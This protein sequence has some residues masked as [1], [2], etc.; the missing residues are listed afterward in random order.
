[1]L[2]GTS[3]TATAAPV[4]VVL[5]VVVVQMATAKLEKKEEEEE[6]NWVWEQAGRCD[7]AGGYLLGCIYKPWVCSVIVW[8]VSQGPDRGE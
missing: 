6:E 1:M 2:A 8:G 4:P 7:I 3:A 5:T